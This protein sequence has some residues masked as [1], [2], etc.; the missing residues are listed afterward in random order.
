MAEV[1]IIQVMIV[2]QYAMKIR[3]AW[4]KGEGGDAHVKVGLMD[5]RG[6]P[7]LPAMCEA[8]ASH[9][10]TCGDPWVFHFQGSWYC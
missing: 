6:C 9:T 5:G 1:E 10:L 2:Y 4:L 7:L 8:L 3:S